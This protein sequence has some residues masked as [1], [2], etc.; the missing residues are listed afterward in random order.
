M[1]C[2]RKGG[3][4]CLAVAGD[5]RFCS[6]MGGK[7]CFAVCP[8]D[9]AITLTALDADIIAAGPDGIRTIPIRDF[10]TNSGNILGKSEI[11]TE[12]LVPA[13][14]K[15][16]KTIFLK[17]RLRNAIDFAIVSVAS[18]ITVAEGVCK[19]ARIVLGAIAPVP[20]RADASEDF[21]KGKKL[22][23]ETAEQASNMAVEKTKPL[24]KNAYKIQITKKLVKQSI[25]AAMT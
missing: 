18:A 19:E 13:L 11:I 9:M 5:N 23:Q 3:K 16:E 17:F 22:T 15:D 4:S 8:S 2:K 21:L 25:M 14:P 24:S 7:G 12:F 10:Y 6:I 20:T 1:L